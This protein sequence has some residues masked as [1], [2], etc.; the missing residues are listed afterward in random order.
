MVVAIA[1][2]AEEV[3]NG[4]ADNNLV[5][6]G[7]QLSAAVVTVVEAAADTGTEVAVVVAADHKVDIVVTEVVSV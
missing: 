7:A 2:I 5:D 3:V 6:L 1:R 4:S